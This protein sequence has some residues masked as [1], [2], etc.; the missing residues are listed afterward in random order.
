VSKSSATSISLTAPDGIFDNAQISITD[1]NG[2]P[3]DDVTP[4]GATFNLGPD[5][6]DLASSPLGAAYATLGSKAELK[7]KAANLGPLPIVTFTDFQGG[8]ASA[9]QVCGKTLT[10]TCIKSSSE[11]SLDVLPPPACSATITANCWNSGMGNV[12]V[13][14]AAIDD[15]SGQPTIIGQE[16]AGFCGY[17]MDLNNGPVVFT[18]S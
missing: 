16:S 18:V 12:N 6:F 10:E 17:T 3:V 11:T 13:Q 1:A 7:F 14:V 9:W 8:S 2:N 15:S 5:V 4:F